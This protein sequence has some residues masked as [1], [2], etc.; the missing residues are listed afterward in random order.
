MN[1]L[2]KKVHIY[3]GLL[4]FSILLV[5]GIA[6]L[7]ATLDPGPERRIRPEPTARYE[8][9]TA[10][11]AANDMEIAEAVYRQLALPLTAPVPKFALRRD[12]DNNLAMDFYTPNGVS[13]VTVLERENRVRVDTT[14]V[15]FWSYL[16]NLHSTTIVQRSADVRMRLWV[17]YN[18]F[19]I[20]SLLGMTFS[21]AYL[22]ISSRPGYGPAR[23]ALGLGCALFI[24]LYVVTR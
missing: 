11:A 16:D 13:R 17:Y 18:E 9:F 10:A 15:G 12:R 8:A 23:Y 3:L 22:G 21:G 4:N 19:A 5:F 7:H 2:I 14:R 6:G 20:W 1:A 24:A